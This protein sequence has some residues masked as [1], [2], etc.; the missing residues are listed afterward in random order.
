VRYGPLLHSFLLLLEKE[1]EAMNKTTPNKYVRNSLQ[2][3][4]FGVFNL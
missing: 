2:A 1:V 3:G 4:D